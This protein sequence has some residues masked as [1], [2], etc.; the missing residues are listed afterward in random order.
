[1]LHCV[2]SPQHFQNLVTYREQHSSA[3]VGAAPSI[4][5]RPGNHS[6]SE[7]DKQRIDEVLDKLRERFRSLPEDMRQE[8]EKDMIERLDQDVL[9]ALERALPLR[10]RWVYRRIA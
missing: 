8:M 5:F 9:G 2:Q 10:K 4:S 3:H 1:M 6:M 7:A